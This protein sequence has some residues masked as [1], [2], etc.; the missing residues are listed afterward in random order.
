MFPHIENWNDMIRLTQ[1]KDEKTPFLEIFNSIK[2]IINANGYSDIK[3]I[4]EFNL[5]F[6]GEIILINLVYQ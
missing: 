6:F 2:D 4:F 3:D 5:G 1:N